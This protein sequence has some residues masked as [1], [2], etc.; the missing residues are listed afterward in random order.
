MFAILCA[1][2]L[3]APAVGGGAA[4]DDLKALQGQWS[5][6]IAEMDGKAPA[7]DVK[8][9]KITLLV[10]GAEYRVLADDKPISGGKL[11]LD[12]SKKPR[13]IDATITEGPHKGTTQ[14]GIY[15][16]KGDTM[17]AAFAKPGGARPTEFKTTEGSG[18]SIVR[19]TRIKK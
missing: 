11:K 9:L 5:A 7:D 14:Q 15:E 19:Y 10:A 1:L 12:A 17:V 13:T 8:S 18:Q 6:T 2:T 4:A 16:I 3:A